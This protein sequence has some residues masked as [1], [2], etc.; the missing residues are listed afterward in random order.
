MPVPQISVLM[1]VRNGLRYVDAAVNSILTQT[2]ADFEFIIVENGSTDG[3][4]EALERWAAKDSRIRLLRNPKDENQSGGLNY[5]LRACRAAWVAR[6]DADDIAL[7]DRFARQ[8]AFVSENPDVKATSCLAYYIDA[9]SRRVGKSVSDLTSREVFERYMAEGRSPGLMHPG[10]LI[11]TELLKRL[12]GYR[13]QFEPANDIDLWCRVADHGVVLVQPE[14]LIEY[15]VHGGSGIARAFSLSLQKAIWA[16]DCMRA[17]RSS[18]PEPTWEQFVAGRRSAPWWLRLN[19][20]RKANAKR[21]YR[22]SA[23]DRISSQMFPA[24]IE[25]SAAA[26][27]QPTYAV[28]RLIG[29]RYRE[30][31]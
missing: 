22:Q 6:M 31:D 13:P 23:L 17:R 19:R 3:T 25:M 11:E 10:A 4:A 30:S 29:Q 16:R 15:R 14:Y 26:L 21:L 27:L 5:G 1:S 18:T 20:W 8:I 7:P 24:V 2:F 12:G 28:R 9:Q